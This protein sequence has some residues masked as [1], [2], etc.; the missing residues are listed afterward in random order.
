MMNVYAEIFQKKWAIIH[1][2]IVV[3]LAAFLFF[4]NMLFAAQD[5]FLTSSKG[6]WKAYP[7]LEGVFICIMLAVFPRLSLAYLT[8]VTGTFVITILGLIC[9]VIFPHILVAII[10]T[11]LFWETDP[12][13]VIFAWFIAFS[14]EVVEKTVIRRR[15]ILVRRPV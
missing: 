1:V 10:A 9:W 6:F 13:L 12:I 14:C 4:P 11:D 7:Q 8:L 2:A 5:V 3:L 15:Y